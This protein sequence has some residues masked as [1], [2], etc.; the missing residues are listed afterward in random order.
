VNHGALTDRARRYAEAHHVFRGS[1][2][3]RNRE[4]QVCLVVGRQG[5]DA[6]PWD[7][8]PLLTHC[9]HADR[10]AGIDART[11]GYAETK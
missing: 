10:A 11:G 1:S 8:E 5:F 6:E 7:C 4:N 2:T 9:A 3:R